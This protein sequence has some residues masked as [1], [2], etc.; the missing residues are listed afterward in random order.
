MCLMNVMNNSLSLDTRFN[1]EQDTTELTLGDPP[2]AETNGR[3]QFIST[4]NLETFRWF[5]FK[6]KPLTETEL[7]K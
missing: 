5:L 2:T 6:L 3:N 7:V 1:L 4:L